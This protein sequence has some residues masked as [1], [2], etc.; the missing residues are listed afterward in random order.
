MVV[1]IIEAPYL[2]CIYPFPEWTKWPEAYIIPS[3][4]GKGH[5]MLLCT[6]KF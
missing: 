4:D 2:L 3:L 1:R 6:A 5:A